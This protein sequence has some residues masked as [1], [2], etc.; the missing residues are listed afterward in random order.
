MFTLFQRR[1]ILTN[2]TSYLPYGLRLMNHINDYEVLSLLDLTMVIIL[3]YKDESDIESRYVYHPRIIYQRFI[4]FR[5]KGFL[6]G[7]IQRF[8]L[9]SLGDDL[10]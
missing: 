3:Y 10:I 7:E 5:L 6:H 1:R 9:L 4:T 8:F 2:D